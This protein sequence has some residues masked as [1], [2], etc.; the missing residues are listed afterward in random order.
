MLLGRYSFKLENGIKNEAVVIRR[1]QT[2][3]EDVQ[4][5][6]CR[7]GYFML[8][9]GNADSVSLAARELRCRLLRVKI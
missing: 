9:S 5:N 7:Y 4:T 1:T 8:F 3:C 2:F 6:D